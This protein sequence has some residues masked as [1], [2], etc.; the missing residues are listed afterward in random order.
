MNNI[1]VDTI[2][3]SYGDIKI[4]TDFRKTIKYSY[5][6]SDNNYY[7]GK[8]VKNYQFVA[9]NNNI[10]K[11]ISFYIKNIHDIHDIKYFTYKTKKIIYVLLSYKNN[12][13]K[14]LDDNFLLE[15]EKINFNYIILRTS[16]NINEIE[17][18]TYDKNKFK[19][20]Y[21]YKSPNIYYENEIDDNI[22]NKKDLILNNVYTDIIFI[23]L[24]NIYLIDIINLTY[25]NIINNG[26]YIY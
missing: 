2:L 12:I 16:Y 14:E 21:I 4:P 13:P 10:N 24:N 17:N 23:P 25:K 9:C 11:F 5:Y 8:V 20:S 15:E 7:I 19:I 22:I 26:S 18:L 3:V 6:L 1:K